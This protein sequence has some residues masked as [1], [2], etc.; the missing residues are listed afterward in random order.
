MPGKIKFGVYELDADSLELRKQGAV[1]R[2]QEQPLRLLVALTERPGEI[3]T[4]EQLQTLIRGKDTFVDFEQSLNKA[5]NRLREALND[6]AGQP[7]Y[8]ETVPRRGYRFVAPVSL[9]D[10]LAKQVGA[11]DA[12]LPPASAASTTQVSA[13]PWRLGSPW[14]LAILAGVFLLLAA[15]T[16]YL[17]LHPAS[18]P[19]QQVTVMPFSTYPGSETITSVYESMSVMLRIS[20]VG[21]VTVSSG[22]VDLT[23]S[24]FQSGSV[25]ELL[26][27]GR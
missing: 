10:G 1:V 14:R 19:A 9:L 15:A 24:G 26:L 27:A 13:R 4:R 8:V 21:S 11:T 22:R 20:H 17:L 7:R 6:D 5:V 2:L 3:V 18:A 25:R 12:P 16:A 23:S